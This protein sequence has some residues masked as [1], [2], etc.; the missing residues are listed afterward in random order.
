MATGIKGF[1]TKLG[2]RADSI[3][4]LEEGLRDAGLGDAD[5]AS[6][7][8][9]Q[10]EKLRKVALHTEIGDAIAVSQDRLGSEFLPDERRIMAQIFEKVVKR[11]GRLP[12]LVKGL[13]TVRDEAQQAQVV[14]LRQQVSG[15]NDVLNNLQAM[16]ERIQAVQNAQVQLQMAQAAAPAPAAAAAPAPAAAAPAPAAAAAPAGA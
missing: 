8:P 12:E 13:Q 16:L 4:V 1:F 7:S 10:L 2:L 15:Q 9:Q 5:L 6:L 11:S 14:A 3:G